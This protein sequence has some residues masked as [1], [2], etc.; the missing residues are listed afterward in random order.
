MDMKK[1]ITLILIGILTF[2]CSNDDDNNSTSKQ[3]TGVWNWTESS[4]GI[5]Y[6]TE[7]PESTGKTVKLEIT[8]STIER[9]VNGILDYESNYTIELLNDNGQQIRI[10][11]FENQIIPLQIIDLTKST[12]KLREYNVSDGFDITY[13]KK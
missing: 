3:L 4:G 2:S 12:L 10:I 5:A 1:I 9:N 7:T 13:T 8:N 6:H 11:T